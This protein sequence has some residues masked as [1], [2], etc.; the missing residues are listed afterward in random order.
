M[1]EPQRD[2]YVSNF[3]LHEGELR[4]FWKM[5]SYFTVFFFLFTALYLFSKLLPFDID[6][7]IGNPLFMLIAALLSTMF[8]I[9]VSG[10]RNVLDETGLRWSRHGGRD[11]LLGFAVAGLLMSALFALELLFGG[12]R[13]SNV[14]LT[15]GY[16]AELLLISLVGFTLVGF[17]EEILMRG[18][19]FTVLQRQG[20]TVLAL[21]LTS[22]L[23]S[24]MHGFNPEIGWLGFGNI[25]LAGIWLGVAR[26]VTG[27]LWLAIG[28]HTGWNFFLGTVFGFPVSGIYERSLLITETTGPEVLSGG[29]FGPEG[30]LLATVVLAI[31]TG[32]LF[33]PAVRRYLGT[34]PPSISKE[35]KKESP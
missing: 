14:H 29:S 20:G 23:F 24:L 3:W 30:G 7:R 33:L 1:E 18:Y 15:A 10:R 21:L 27:T 26:L 8:L 9:A 11:L 32:T 16:V 2:E 35:T 12:A 25:F 22:V 28:M 17:A 4:L 5:S 13:I 31:G 6:W 19:P 34:M